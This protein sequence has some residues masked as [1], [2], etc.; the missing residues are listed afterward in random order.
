MGR[1]ENFAADEPEADLA[2][3][4][5][6]VALVADVDEHQDNA[7]RV[8]LMTL[9]SA[10][11]LEFPFVFIAGV[12]EGL[13]PHDRALES[14]DLN[15]LEEERR[16]FYVGVTRA[17]KVLYLSRAAFRFNHGSGNYCVPSRFLD[18]IPGKLIMHVTYHQGREK[19]I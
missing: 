15:E 6:D 18:E 5:Q 12:D 4:L 14:Y 11:G 16:L 10:Q 19:Q 17:R 13:L 8:S 7:S 1:V 9:H 2:A 3:F